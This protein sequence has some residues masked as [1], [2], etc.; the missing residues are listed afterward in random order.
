MCCNPLVDCG[1][2]SITL[3]VQAQLAQ[4][5][6]ELLRCRTKLERTQRELQEARRHAAGAATASATSAPAAPDGAVTAQ[7]SAGAIKPSESASGAVAEHVA[8]AS[9]VPTT[10]KPRCAGLVQRVHVPMTDPHSAAVTAG[11][12]TEVVN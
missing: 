10:S 4:D 3:Q 12:E 11:R 9:E 8:P 7:G 5:R 2:R 1:S 6:E